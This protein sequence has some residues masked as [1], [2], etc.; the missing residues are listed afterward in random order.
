MTS[1]YKAGNCEKNKLLIILRF[2][3]LFLTNARLF[4]YTQ[5]KA[6]NLF[7]DGNH[8]NILL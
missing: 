4:N 7:L 1:K 3:L 5:M 2:G 8:K 6:K